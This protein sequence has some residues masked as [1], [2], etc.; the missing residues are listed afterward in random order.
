MNKIIEC[1]YKR[2]VQTIKNAL[3][4]LNYNVNELDWLG[5]QMKDDRKTP[6]TGNVQAEVCL[7]LVHIN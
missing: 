5:P 6:D 7:L 3:L 1:N 4:Y 2:Y